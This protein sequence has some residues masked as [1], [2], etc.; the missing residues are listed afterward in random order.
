MDF[1]YAAF[2]YLYEWVCYDRRFMKALEFREGSENDQ[3]FARK[4]LFAVAKHYDIIRNF[5]LKK[6]G[7]RLLPAWNALKEIA[8]PTS[9]QDA[10][11]CVSQLVENLRR[12]YG[13][14]PWSAASKFLWMRFQSLIVI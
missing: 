14:D 2:I 12:P 3:E 11:E 8:K 7:P 5:K 13:L 10:K 6:E 9:Q 4:E 1:R